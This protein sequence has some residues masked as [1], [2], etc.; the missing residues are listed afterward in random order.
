MSSPIGTWVRVDQI[1]WNYDLEILGILLTVDLRVMDMSEFDAVLGMDRLTSHRVVID[2]D[3]RRVTTNTLDGTCVTFQGDKHEA[4][5][6]AV[7]DSKW[8]GKL[9]GWLFAFFS[10]RLNAPQIHIV[11]RALHFSCSHVTLDK[12]A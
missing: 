5:P 7:Y 11:T 1:C 4:L 8:N 3:R 10:Y 2:C 12:F 6:R 9:I